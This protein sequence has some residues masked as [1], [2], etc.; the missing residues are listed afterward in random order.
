M[1]IYCFMS[2]L[3]CFHWYRDVTIT[4]IPMYDLI[5]EC[6]SYH[7]RISVSNLFSTMKPSTS[8]S[9]PLA[10]SKCVPPPRGNFANLSNLKVVVPPYL[11]FFPMFNF[12]HIRNIDWQW[13]NTCYV[14]ISKKFN[15]AFIVCSYSKSSIFMI[16]GMQKNKPLSMALC[17]KETLYDKIF[18]HKVLISKKLHIWVF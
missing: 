8:S 9:S 15:L 10:G 4:D 6:L 7:P 13:G 2:R 16:F 5:W 18:N 1:I 14:K 11:N 3:N 12:L 17:E